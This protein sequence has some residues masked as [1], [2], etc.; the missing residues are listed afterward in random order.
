MS[1]A[2]TRLGYLALVPFVG[3]AVAV[4]LTAGNSRPVF[5][6][7]LVAYAAVVISFIGGIHWGFAFPNGDAKPGL[8]IW[9]VVPSIV[10]WTA[11]L[12]DPRFGLLIHAATLVVCYRVDRR[13]YPQ[14][15]AEAWLPLRLRLTFVAT[16]SCLAGA[17]AN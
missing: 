4:F 16:L 7:A 2:A 3:C 10:A 5:L 15:R 6:Q 8:V 9:G 12:I 1:A 17:A 11:L 14:H 13:V